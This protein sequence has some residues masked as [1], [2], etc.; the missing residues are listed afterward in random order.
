MKVVNNI[1][2]YDIMWQNKT[3]IDPLF[4]TTIIM[5][6]DAGSI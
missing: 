6:L 4:Y 5:P 1:Y 3:G 2:E